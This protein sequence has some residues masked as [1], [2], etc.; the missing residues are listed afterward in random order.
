MP[1]TRQTCTPS[2]TL[3]NNLQHHLFSRPGSAPRRPKRVKKKSKSLKGLSKTLITI[4]LQFKHSN[5]VTLSKKTT[6]QSLLFMSNAARSFK[7]ATKKW[8]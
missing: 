4:S 6:L 1:R 2:S 3:C 7:S 5:I 8:K